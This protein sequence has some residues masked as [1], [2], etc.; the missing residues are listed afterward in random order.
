ME[1][2]ATQKDKDWFTEDT[3]FAIAQIARAGMQGIRGYAEAI[4]LSQGIAY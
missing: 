4:L 3:F 2:F 1:C